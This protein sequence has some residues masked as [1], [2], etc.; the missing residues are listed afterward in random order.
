MR[1]KKKI[2]DMRFSLKN[3]GGKNEEQIDNHYFHL[4][5]TCIAT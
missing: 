1:G 4:I 5:E 3:G 2:I